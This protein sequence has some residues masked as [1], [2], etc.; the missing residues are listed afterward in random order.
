M[1]GRLG[2]ASIPLPET[3]LSICADAYVVTSE[4]GRDTGKL[5]WGDADGPLTVDLIGTTGAHAGNTIKA[6]ARVR[7]DV[8][9]LCYT[10][11]GSARPDGFDVAS[12][13]P[14]VTVRYR[15]VRANA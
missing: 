6:I 15:R 2:G 4:T 9:Q 12:G 11:D 13:T 10:V 7:G 3:T 1:G 5:V 8:M 14:V